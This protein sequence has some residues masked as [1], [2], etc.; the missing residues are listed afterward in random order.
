MKNK[1]LLL[2]SAFWLLASGF[3]ISSCKKGPGEGGNSS[4][5]GKVWA[6]DCNSDFTNVEKEHDGAD[7]DVYIIYGD[8]ISYGDRIKTDLEGDFEFK[9][10]RKGKYK[11][12]VY[13]IDSTLYDPNGGLNP[14]PSPIAYSKEELNIT[15]RKQTVDVGTFRIWR[16]L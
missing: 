8:D 3:F 13:S 16:A 1:T 9:Y 14:I 5:K 7:V 2:A 10:L 11:I 12:Y 6:I 15:D 4:I